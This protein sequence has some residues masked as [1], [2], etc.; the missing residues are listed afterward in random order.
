MFH[1]CGIYILVM[2]NLRSI[3]NYTLFNIKIMKKGLR[4]QR[5]YKIKF[6]H[7]NGSQLKMN[8]AMRVWSYIYGCT[9][10][11]V[12]TRKSMWC[13][14][15]WSP[16]TTTATPGIVITVSDPHANY[17]PETHMSVSGFLYVRHIPRCKHLHN[18]W[19]QSVIKIERDLLY[20][21]QTNRK[22]RVS[23]KNE[24]TKF[25]AGLIIVLTI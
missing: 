18:C 10:P 8:A 23:G 22:I 6:I 24:L 4:W 15:V 5:I 11:C 17:H 7:E 21:L 14:F 12:C 3:L 13:V 25:Y 9:Y 1:T 2:M 16:V 19:G 20:P